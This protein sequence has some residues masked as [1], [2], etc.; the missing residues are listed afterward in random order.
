M[1]PFKCHQYNHKHW[2]KIPS[3]HK[4]TTQCTRIAFGKWW[5]RLIYWLS[6]VS[7][8]VLESCIEEYHGITYNKVWEVEI[9]DSARILDSIYHNKKC[10]I[11]NQTNQWTQEGGL[12]IFIWCDNIQHCI[13]TRTKSHSS[14]LK[15]GFIFS[16]T[17]LPWQLHRISA[18]TEQNPYETSQKW[19]APNI[20]TLI[21]TD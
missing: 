11:S 7:P 14:S 15:F 6:K 9:F 19:K 21:Y 10:S 3:V 12:N 13:F 18:P 2:C 1:V 8:G 17:K 20:F 16:A 5:R 4:Q